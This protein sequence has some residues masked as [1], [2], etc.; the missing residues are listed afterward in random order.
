[1]TKLEA[2]VQRQREGAQFVLSAQMLGMGVVEFDAIATV[3]YD[4][5]GPGF[6]VI[7]T[8]FRQVVED[9]FLITRITVIKTVQ[10]K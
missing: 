2:I 10:R 5:G 4:D 8:P 6:N 9:D 3:W 1:M 7:G